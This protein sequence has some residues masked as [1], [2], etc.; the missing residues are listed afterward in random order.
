MTG[1]IFESI[2]KALETP[3][4]M[5]QDVRDTLIL[6]GIIS[7]YKEMD[8]IKTEMQELKKMVPLYRVL[9]VMGGILIPLVIG[10]LWSI[11]VGKTTVN[12]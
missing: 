5:S 2:K 6:T 9:V 1:T 10:F 11:F 7:L 8:S 4:G 12:F 3:G